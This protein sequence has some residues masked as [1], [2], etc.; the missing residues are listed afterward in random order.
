FLARLVET[1]GPTGFEAPVVAAW[2]EYVRGFADETYTDAY[3]NGYAVLNPGGDPKVVLTGHADEIG[4]MASHIDDEGFIWVSS[5]G[6]Y[7]AKILPGMRVRVYGSGPEVR[8]GSGDGP[9]PTNDGAQRAP[10]PL[11]G[12]IGALPPHMQNPDQGGVELK[13]YRFGE[14]VYVDI[15]AKDKADTEKYVRVG[16]A[17]VLDYGYS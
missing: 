8:T 12:V 10:V 5:L 1:P 4:L 11:A 13:R 3:G 15:G 2:L 14:N 6:G 7:D 9:S 17:M 16:D